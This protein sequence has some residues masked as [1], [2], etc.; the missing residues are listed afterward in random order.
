MSLNLEGIFTSFNLSYLIC[1]R[2]MVV[3]TMYVVIY[4]VVGWYNKEQAYNV[5]RLASM[6]TSAIVLLGPEPRRI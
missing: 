4:I 6:F 5:D 2:A 1:D 3:C